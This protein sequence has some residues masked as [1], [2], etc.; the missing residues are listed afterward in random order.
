M[1]VHAALFF[2]ICLATIT[3]VVINGAHIVL[4]G[5]KYL[6]ASRSSEMRIDR[7][8]EG[9]CKLMSKHHLGADGL[10]VATQPL[11][12]PESSEEEQSRRR[13]DSRAMQSFC[14]RFIE[15]HEDDLAALLKIE[16]SVLTRAGKCTLSIH[17]AHRQC[18][19]SQMVADMT[20]QIAQVS[21]STMRMN[22]LYVMWQ[23]QYAVF[24]QRASM[25]NSELHSV[26]K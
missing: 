2:C 10:W 26:C 8:L 24:M 11:P 5:S 6:L 17:R 21:R 19:I 25:L 9:F 18:M 14:E 15:D 1:G 13:H 3:K 20:L 7:L 23:D 16:D 12:A 22:I 4:N